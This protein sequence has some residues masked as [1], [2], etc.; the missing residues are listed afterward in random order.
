[1]NLGMLRMFFNMFYTGSILCYKDHINIFYQT[2]KAHENYDDRK[3]QFICINN[4]QRIS[5]ISIITDGYKS[6]IAL[7]YILFITLSLLYDSFFI[8][9]LNHDGP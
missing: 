3:V 6:I 4:N 8:V 1:M 9:S 7:N 2:R 5:R